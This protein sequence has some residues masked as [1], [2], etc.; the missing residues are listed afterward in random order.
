MS[1]IEVP[2]VRL[3]GM[4]RRV[5]TVLRHG[6]LALGVVLLLWIPFSYSFSFWLNSPRLYLSVLEG[7]LVCQW[8]YSTPLF[9]AEVEGVEV[10][11]QLL[12][13]DMLGAVSP[14]WL[15]STQLALPAQP[16]SIIYIPLWLLAAVCLAWPS[17][18]FALARRRLGGRGFAVE[19]ARSTPAA[20][21]D[22]QV[23][24]ATGADGEGG[25]ARMK[26][27]G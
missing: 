19:A 15:S 4:L 22:A 2:E 23:A 5:S 18:S 11:A 16:R 21:G 25:A 13:I 24:A 27:K 8:T 20:A 6:L 1:D 3:S 14:V 9:V 12:S 17:M 10:G 26:D 7:V